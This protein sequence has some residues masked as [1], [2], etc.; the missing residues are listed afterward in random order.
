VSLGS[1][2]ET[3]PSIDDWL[4]AVNGREGEHSYCPFKYSRARRRS[5]RRG[6]RHLVRLAG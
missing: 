3:L 5:E 6:E 4:A 1:T 2:L